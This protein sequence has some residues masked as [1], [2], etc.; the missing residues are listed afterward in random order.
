[1]PPPGSDSIASVPATRFTRCRIADSPKPA[2]ALVGPRLAGTVEADAVVADVERHDVAHVGQ[3][4]PGARGA[5]VL[6]DVGQRLL[7]GPQQRHLDLGV[8][9]LDVAGR[10]H[11]DR[12]AVQLRPLPGDLG[13]RLGQPGGLEVL[14]PRALDRP[15]RLGQALAGQADRVPDV[16][17]PVLGPVARLLGRLELGDDPGQALGDRVVDLARPCAAAR[18]ARRPRGP[19]SAAGRGGRRSPRA[20][21]RAGP[22]PG[23]AAR[24]ARPAARRGARRPRSRASG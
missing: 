18:R 1:M 5:G 21:P 11:L 22:P 9:R 23:A 7:R 13:E 6:G 12:H 15:A 16:P 19:G 20:P 17:L 3:G 10:G 14:G 24:S 4:Q 2:A 8:E